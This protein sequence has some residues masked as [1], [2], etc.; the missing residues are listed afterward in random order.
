MLSLRLNLHFL[1]FI[2][3]DMLHREISQY[4]YKG[5]SWSK[6]INGFLYYNLLIETKYL[7]INKSRCSP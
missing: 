1:T 4:Q 5:C 3:I 7:T 2:Y 6:L